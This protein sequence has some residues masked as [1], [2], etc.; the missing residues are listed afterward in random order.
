MWEKQWERDHVEDPGE[1]CRIILRFIF[2]KW[3]YEMD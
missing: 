1:D 2:R 3:E